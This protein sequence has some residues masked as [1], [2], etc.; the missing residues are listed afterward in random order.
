MA[1]ARTLFRSE[2]RQSLSPAGVA[3]AVHRGMLDIAENGEMFLTASY[4]VLQRANGRLR[5][6][7]GGHE[8]PLLLHRGSSHVETLPGRGRFLGMVDP[9]ELEEY[10]IQLQPGDRLL[11]FSDGVTD[12]I[13]AAGEL[14]GHQR[15]HNRFLA[16]AGLRSA[17]VLPAIADDVRE[18]CGIADP[19]DDLT[20]MLVEYAPT[21]AR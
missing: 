19:A 5:Y 18:W 17:D 6:I 2:S 9:L 21:P 16:S 11:L 10:E 13:N 7:S 12:T 1:V 4:A 8:H 14:F 20:M 15:L 3:L